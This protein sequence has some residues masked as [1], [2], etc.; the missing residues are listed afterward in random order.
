MNARTALL[1]GTTLLLVACVPAKEPI[2]WEA[3]VIAPTHWRTAGEPLAPIPDHWWQTF[4][5]PQ[6]TLL[7]ET[8]LRHNTDVL[9]AV[10]RVDEAYQHIALAR[11]AWWP[12][13]AAAVTGQRQRS[14]SALGTVAHPRTVQPQLQVAYEA[15][16][17]GR[18]RKL[19]QAQRNQYQASL[20]ERDAVRLTVASTTARAYITL[21]S[22]DGQLA[23][24]RETVASRVGALRVAEDRAAVGYTSQLELTQAQSEYESVLQRIFQLEQAIREQEDALRVLTGAMPG[25]IR[26]SQPLDAVQLPKVP[27]MLPAQLLRRRPDI[28]QAEQLL[29]AT[30]AVLESRRD[31]FLPRVQL[32]ASIGQLYTNSL[33]YNPVKV[34]SLGSSILTPIYTSGR[35]QAQVGIASAQ[36]DQAAYAYRATTLQAFAEMED[37]LS[38]VIRLQQQ[39]DH[40]LARRTVLYRSLEIARDRYRN[41]YSSYLQE[42]DAQRNLF[43][44]D[45]LAVQVR[46]GQLNNLIDLYQALG[47]GWAPAYGKAEQAAER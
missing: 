2:P 28:A 47:G 45:L 3:K 32:S 21:L 29:A 17:W 43:E 20:A 9:G 16:I 42:L 37:A 33:D 6:L 12:D 1:F 31:E 8:A 41:G 40:I 24:T 36:R 15:D 19:E 34:W 10:A 23:V 46:E 11:S 38:G 44:N 39:I 22:L 5:D 7:V 27:G 30:D 35:L 13:V 14:L 18:L 4:D 26:R 25:H